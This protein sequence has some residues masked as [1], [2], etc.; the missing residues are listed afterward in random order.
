MENP[1]K[2]LEDLK[3][4]LRDGRI[5]YIVN[6][7]YVVDNGTVRFLC[8]EVY[9]ERIAEIATQIGLSGFVFHTF[10]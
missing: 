2:L 4:E 8:H 9:Q 1:Y 10:H 6:Y 3:V 7:A 5:K